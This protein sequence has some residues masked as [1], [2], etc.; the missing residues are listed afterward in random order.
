MLITITH[1]PGVETQPLMRQTIANCGPA[2]IRR[3]VDRSMISEVLIVHREGSPPPDPTGDS[4]V[5]GH[6]VSSE[7]RGAVHGLLITAGEPHAPQG[8]GIADAAVR[9]WQARTLG[10]MALMAARHLDMVVYLPRGARRLRELTQPS[11]EDDRYAR[12]RPSARQLQGALEQL[13]AQPAELVDHAVVPLAL[14]HRTGGR[15]KLGQQVEA[16]AGCWLADSQRWE[17]TPDF[18]A[19][20]TAAAEAGL[21]GLGGRPGGVALVVVERSGAWTAFEVPACTAAAMCA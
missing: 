1:A 4:T 20:R 15:W 19:A 2:I 11:A 21:R 13:R 18:N 17:S 16:V 9:A 5:E 7:R 10:I 3:Q 6:H 14:P 12:L 8:S